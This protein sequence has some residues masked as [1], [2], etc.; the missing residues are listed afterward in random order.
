METKRHVISPAFRSFLFVLVTYGIVLV[1]NYLNDG[2]LFRQGK[3]DEG[4]GFYAFPLMLTVFWMAIA[5]I[6]MF[7]YMFPGE[8]KLNR[9][10]SNRMVCKCFFAIWYASIL[11]MALFLIS[12]TTR[13]GWCVALL[14]IVQIVFA[15]TGTRLRWIIDHGSTYASLLVFYLVSG[16]IPLEYQNFCYIMIALIQCFFLAKLAT[17]GEE[18][19]DRPADDIPQMMSEIDK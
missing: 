6:P 17:I 5:N 8:I 4:K 11:L 10:F 16:S 1:L 7:S 14:I 13:Y 15:Y 18:L 9:Y 2:N 3:P 12:M 19:S